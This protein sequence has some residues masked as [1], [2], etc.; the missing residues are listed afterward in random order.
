LAGSDGQHMTKGTLARVGGVIAVV[1]SLIG[2][3][4]WFGVH[5]S[6]MLARRV[7]AARDGKTRHAARGASPKSSKVREQAID[8]GMAPVAGVWQYHGGKVVVA[9]K[10]FAGYGNLTAA[11]PFATFDARGWDTFTCS[12]GVND[13]HATPAPEFDAALEVDGESLWEQRLGEG[14]RPETLQVRLHGHRAITLR[15]LRALN[16]DGTPYAGEIA[17]LVFA[18]PKLATQGR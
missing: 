17:E 5:S 16:A 7:T 15:C 4:N 2:I 3:L 1:A 8:G 11:T 18:E 13:S 6:E 14:R 12:I 10:V 9:G